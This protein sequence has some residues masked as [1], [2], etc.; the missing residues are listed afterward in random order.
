M[1]S[2]LSVRGHCDDMFFCG[3]AAGEKKN[4]LETDS[5]VLRRGVVVLSSEGEEVDWVLVSPA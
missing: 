5:D 3:Y 4:I 1:N 2:H